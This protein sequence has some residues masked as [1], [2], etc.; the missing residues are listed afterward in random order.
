MDHCHDLRHARAGFVM[1][2]AY[3]GYGTPFRLGEATGNVL[4][5]GGVLRTPKN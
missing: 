5:V 3:E 1:H 4:R 2:L